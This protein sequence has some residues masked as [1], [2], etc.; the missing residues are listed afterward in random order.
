VEYKRI[1]EPNPPHLS[2]RIFGFFNA[3]DGPFYFVSD[4]AVNMIG[5]GGFVIFVR[6][7]V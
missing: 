3:V 6:L 2:V 1:C 4:R 5:S 7:F